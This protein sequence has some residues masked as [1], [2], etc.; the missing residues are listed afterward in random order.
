VGPAAGAQPNPAG[1]LTAA[2]LRSR[3]RRRRCNKNQSKEDVAT[4]EP[5]DS[6]VARADAV[7]ELANAQLGSIGRGKVSASS[8]Y[9]IARFNAWVSFTGFTS[10]ADM[11]SRRAETL[12]YFVAQYRATLEDH[13]DDYA[14]HFEEYMRGHEA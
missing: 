14:E 1:A 3:W 4:T 6:F 13:L 9:A 8:M 10:Q 11:R 12:D 2:R 7:I 5:D